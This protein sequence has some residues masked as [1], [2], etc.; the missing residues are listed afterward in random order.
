MSHILKE[1]QQQHNLLLSLM[2][3]NHLLKIMSMSKLL[4]PLQTIPFLLKHS[5]IHTLTK[6]LAIF[7]WHGRRPRFPVHKL[8]NNNENC[9]MAFP[10]IRRYNLACMARHIADWINGT[11]HYLA[12]SQERGFCAP[13][14]LVALLHARLIN[15]PDWIEQSI[16]IKDTIATWR[17]LRKKYWLSFRISKHLSLWNNPEFKEGQTNSLFLEWKCKGITQV[18]QLMYDR[19]PRWLIEK[20][21]IDKFSLDPFQVIQFAQIKAAITSKLIVYTGTQSFILLSHKKVG[22]LQEKL[23][24]GCAIL[25][26][27]SGPNNL[28]IRPLGSLAPGTKPIAQLHSLQGIKASEPNLDNMS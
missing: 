10:D 5:N 16:L 11:S 24:D 13:C 2:G 1:L 21:L 12:L 8:M 4:Y 22:P 17:I 18:K 6:A 26:I 25:D 23:M 20:E 15:I 28:N 7:R 19:E 9:G 14:S 3:R 27:H